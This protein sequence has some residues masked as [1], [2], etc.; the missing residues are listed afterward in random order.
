MPLVYDH[1]T[2]QRALDELGAIAGELE[3]KVDLKKL[4]KKINVKWA[5][6]AV[7]DLYHR[8]DSLLE[9][10]GRSQQTHAIDLLEG[11]TREKCYLS[12]FSALYF[13]NLIDQRPTSHYLSMDLH[14]PREVRGAINN[15][16]MRQSFMKSAK[17]TTKVG[18]FDRTTFYFIER[19]QGG[20]GVVTIDMEEDDI[21]YK[22]RVTNV[23]RTLLDSIIAPQYA[24]GVLTV[25]EAMRQ[26]PISTR[27]LI[28]IY[29]SLGLLYPYWQRVGFLLDLAG[30]R[31]EAS[32]WHDSFKL[33]KTEFYLEH[34]YRDTWKFDPKWS[35]YF[36][37]GLK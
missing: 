18:V 35:L 29:S 37:A 12:H 15:L 32:D 4:K 14:R 25:V 7:V 30:K 8:A 11:W 34:E 3:H 23:E 31:E 36:P 9:R 33:S 22:L 20:E 5:T 1:H 28:R 16:A 19:N 2:L 26:A 13:N 17:T 6:G 21:S 27:E 10:Q 24:G